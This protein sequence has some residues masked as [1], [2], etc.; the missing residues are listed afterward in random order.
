MIG[1][2]YNETLAVISC[3]LVFIGFNMVFFTQ[4]ILGA[5]GMPRRY[6]NYLD[7]FQPLHAF[8]TS[9]TWVLGLGFIIMLVYLIHS[10]FRG[11]KASSNPWGGITLE[12]HTDSPPPFENFHK[13]P[14]VHHDPYDYEKVKING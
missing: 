14:I 10:L 6:Y 8:S 3:A 11:K 4:F 5:K 12:W 1:K 13:T 7:Q 2:L 9:G